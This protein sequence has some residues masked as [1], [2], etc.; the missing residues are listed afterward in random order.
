MIT[1]RNKNH[2]RE[3]TKELF[4]IKLSVKI[5]II[6]FTE[7]RKIFG[8]FVNDVIC[9]NCN[10]LLFYILDG[11]NC[12]GRVQTINCYTFNLLKSRW[13]ELWVFSTAVPTI[14]RDTC[15]SKVQNLVDPS[16]QNLE[17]A[18]RGPNS[19]H[20]DSYALSFKGPNKF[21]LVPIILDRFKIHRK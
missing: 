21:G 12:F 5:F 1:S 15:I 14:S 11:P 9:F 4:F 18:Q 8:T 20:K 6:F 10:A 16:N 7:I 19:A 2:V 13:T 3:T 17:R